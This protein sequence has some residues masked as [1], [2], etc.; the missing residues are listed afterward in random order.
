MNELDH[1]NPILC[2]VCRTMI[3]NYQQDCF[4]CPCSRVFC[5][6]C[7]AEIPKEK[8]LEACIE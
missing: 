1:I 3:D 6:N 4:T 8:C 5:P 7:N 2:K